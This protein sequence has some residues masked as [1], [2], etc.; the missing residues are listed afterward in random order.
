[1]KKIRMNNFNPRMSTGADIYVTIDIFKF[2]KD[3]DLPYLEVL[4][5]GNDGYYEFLDEIETGLPVMN[6]EKL[7]E[8]AF[9]WILENVSIADDLKE[10][11]Q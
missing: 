5:E 9:M 1:M 2:V 8:I 3:E 10:G 7:K 6:H 4:I 11:K